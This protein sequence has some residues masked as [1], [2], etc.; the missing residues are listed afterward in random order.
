M[1]SRSR[2]AAMSR[3]NQTIVIIDDDDS[4]RRALRR[5]I[6]SVGLS[7]T[8]FGT[9]EEFLSSD[10]P[11]PGCLILDVHLPGLSGLD[12]QKQ[13]TAEGRRFPIVFISAYAEDQVRHSALQ[14]G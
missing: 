8:T 9:A 4:V 12:L 1:R 14:D 13:L 2:T 6:L 10:Q 7:V 11:A 5:L 3:T